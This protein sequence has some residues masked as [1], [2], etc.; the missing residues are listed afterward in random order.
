V[1]AAV[2]VVC[3]V[4]VAM[5]AEHF[6]RITKIDGDKVTFVKG[7]K[8][9]EKGEEVTLTLAK[10]AKIVKGTFDKETKKVVAGDAIEGGKTA[11]SDMLTK[12]GEKGVGAVI[13]T[14]A[15]DKNITEIRVLKG[16]KGKGAN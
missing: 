3:A 5:S 6:G 14:D 15:D 1:C 7:K 12:A 13:V 11:L 10:D 4:S 9:G 16:K 8:K 2:V